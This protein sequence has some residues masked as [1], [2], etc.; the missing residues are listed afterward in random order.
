[1]DHSD[2]PALAPQQIQTYLDWL[3]ADDEFLD[4]CEQFRFRGIRTRLIY[5][6]F[7]IFS[8]GRP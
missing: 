2:S 4:L 1:M 7:A 3:E 8:S 5:G 6:K